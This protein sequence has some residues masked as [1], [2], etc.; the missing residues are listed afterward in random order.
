MDLIYISKPLFVLF[1]LLLVAWQIFL[2]F[3]KK[4]ATLS[5]LVEIILTIIG[6]LA[7][8]VAITVILLFGGTLS[9]ALVLVLLSGAV[10][11]ALSPTPKPKEEE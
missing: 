4:K 1:P 9:D 8:A 6:V 3:L 7:H 2:V 10:S 11:L 5:S